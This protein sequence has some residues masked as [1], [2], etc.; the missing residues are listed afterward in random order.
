MNPDSRRR[1]RNESFRIFVTDEA[2][3]FLRSHV[4]IPSRLDGNLILDQLLLVNVVVV[5]GRIEFDALAQLL[6]AHQP[7]VAGTHYQVYIM[8]R[9]DRA[10]R[11]CDGG[12]YGLGRGRP[13]HFLLLLFFLALR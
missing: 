10:V 9:H 4:R 13:T 7:L 3:V 2:D 8:Q 12:I 11:V 6:V 5:G 1:R